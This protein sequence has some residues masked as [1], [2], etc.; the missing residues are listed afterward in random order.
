MRDRL[1]KHAVDAEIAVPIE[2]LLGIDEG[3]VLGRGKGDVLRWLFQQTP[4]EIAAENLDRPAAVRQVLRRARIRRGLVCCGNFGG[5]RFCG[6]R[7]SVPDRRPRRRESGGSD[8][9]LLQ[10]S[11]SA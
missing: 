3:P 4:V 9:R 1:A 2:V 11:P 6:K 8:R 7:I 10:E 5:L